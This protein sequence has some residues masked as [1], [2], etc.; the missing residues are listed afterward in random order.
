MAKINGLRYMAPN[1][2]PANGFLVMPLEN[3]FYMGFYN[4]ALFAK[5]GIASVPR[6]WTQLYAACGKLAKIGASS[7]FANNS[8]CR[9]S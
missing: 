5:A 2:N 6:T 7:C 4:K 1:F 3:Q 9:V 8:A